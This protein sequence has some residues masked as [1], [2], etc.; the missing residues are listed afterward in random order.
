METGGAASAPGSRNVSGSSTVQPQTHTHAGPELSTRSIAPSS[1]HSS[2]AHPLRSAAPA[3]SIFNHRF[4][5]PH[6]G[7]DS[8]DS[9][10][11]S[12]VAEAAQ[13]GGRG[14]RGYMVIENDWRGGKVVD[15]EAKGLEGEKKGRWGLK[16]LKGRK[17]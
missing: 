3:I 4:T 9:S 5:G 14:G 16:G 17:S 1:V 15:G 11:A 8:D 2:S 6:D 7:G 10:E 12:R 13:K